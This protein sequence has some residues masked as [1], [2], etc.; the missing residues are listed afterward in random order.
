[1]K[2]LVL[3]MLWYIFCIIST[4]SAIFSWNVLWLKADQ[5]T[6]VLSGL[7]ESMMDLNN[8]YT[9]SSTINKQPNYVGNW[10]NFNPSM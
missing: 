9:A 10:I 1:M 8:N 2:K 3:I 7:V 5:N 4:T 6:I